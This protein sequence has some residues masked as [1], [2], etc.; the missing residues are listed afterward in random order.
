M[1][2][3]WDSLT[4]EGQECVLIAAFFIECWI[5]FGVLA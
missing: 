1:I 3:L 2:K 4:D 5:L